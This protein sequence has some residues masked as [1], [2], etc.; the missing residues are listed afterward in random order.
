MQN[1]RTVTIS[2]YVT[3][4]RYRVDGRIKGLPSLLQAVIPPIVPEA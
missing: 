3:E 2:D 1:E 4:Q